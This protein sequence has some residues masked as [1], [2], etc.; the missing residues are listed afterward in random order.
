MVK[1]Q[2]QENGEHTFIW[3]YCVMWLW[4]T[5]ISHWKNFWATDLV[6]THQ[7]WAFS[8]LSCLGWVT[9]LKGT[10]TSTSTQRLSTVTEFS[11]F[12]FCVNISWLFQGTLAQKVKAEVSIVC[13]WK[14]FFF[15]KNALNDHS[16]T[17][18][19]KRKHQQTIYFP[20]FS[21]NPCCFSCCGHQS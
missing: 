14:F 1:T 19:F 10:K 4:A 6:W 12:T 16:F 11:Y 3:H 18:L 20:R 13:S 5:N 8:T 2:C 7:I 15:L 17:Q 21:L 9:W